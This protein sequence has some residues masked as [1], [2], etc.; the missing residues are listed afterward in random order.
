MFARSR[1][2]TVAAF[3]PPALPGFIAMPTAIPNQPLV[4][5]S[6]FHSRPA[7]SLPVQPGTKNWLAAWL[8]FVHA[9]LL[10]AVCDPGVVSKCSSLAPLHLLPAASTTASAHPNSEH[11]GANYQIQ[12]LTLHL[13]ASVQLRASPNDLSRRVSVAGSFDCQPGS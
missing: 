4:C 1:L 8:A 10:D 2:K 7:Y 5:R 12:R 3:A 11:N 13:A 9:V 6:P